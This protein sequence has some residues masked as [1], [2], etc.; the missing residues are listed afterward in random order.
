MDP[1]SSELT[2]SRH[3][4]DPVIPEL[5]VSHGSVVSASGGNPLYSIRPLALLMWDVTMMWYRAN[6][7]EYLGGLI[8]CGKTYALNGKLC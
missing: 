5:T 3:S 8:L 1:V 7:G 6:H 2:V 4:V